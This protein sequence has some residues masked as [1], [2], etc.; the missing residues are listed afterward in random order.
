M[1]RTPQC[2]SEGRAPYSPYAEP[3]WA[4][5]RGSEGS[6]S[7]APDSPV[8]TSPSSPTVT[9]P[10]ALD[11]HATP[12]PTA[13]PETRHAGFGAA[14]GT[15]TLRQRLRTLREALA[16][17]LQPATC[18]TAG[19][20]PCGAPQP[21][22]APLTRLYSPSLAPA[23]P[24]RQP[25]QRPAPQGT[26]GG[27]PDAAGGAEGAAGA[28]ATA[29]A[30]AAGGMVATG[31]AKA[32]AGGARSAGGAEAACGAEMPRWLLEAA[33][34]LQHTS[35]PPETGTTRGV[36]AQPHA[37]GDDHWLRRLEM[38]ALSADERAVWEGAM[39]GAA[40]RW[41]L[42]NALLIRPQVRVR[43]A[44]KAWRDSVAVLGDVVRRVV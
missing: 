22:A 41:A 26:P 40:R 16:A 24:L 25:S 33:A 29:S 8:P 1:Q 43:R 34:T 2:A 17:A 20:P 39:S 21:A 9:V 37:V 5:P 30:G 31:V 7:S 6:E 15:A 19:L 10:H 14:L 12:P 42:E 28:V 13:S 4:P 36:P 38:A 27:T 11:A 32:A 23:S 3:P 44:L 18:D 35:A